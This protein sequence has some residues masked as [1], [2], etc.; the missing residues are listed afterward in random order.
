MPDSYWNDELL[1][2]KQVEGILKSGVPGGVFGYPGHSS[3]KL[4]LD[5]KNRIVYTVIKSN[6]T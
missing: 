6:I 3:M 5:R 2:Y 4:T 1:Y